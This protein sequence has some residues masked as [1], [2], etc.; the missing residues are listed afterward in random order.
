MTTTQSPGQA[1]SNTSY[2]LPSGD[3]VT[4]VCPAGPM[5]HPGVAPN[6]VG[7]CVF[8]EEHHDIPPSRSCM[9]QLLLYCSITA[10]LI[11]VTCVT[12]DSD[13]AHAAEARSESFLAGKAAGQQVA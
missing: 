3:R 6:D 8:A 10:K 7:T 4:V 2:F 5:R 1:C 13:I 12:I 11:A 9:L